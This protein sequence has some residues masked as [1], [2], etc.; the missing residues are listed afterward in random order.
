MVTDVELAV[1]AYR[2]YVLS[3]ANDVQLADRALGTR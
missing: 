3:F 1:L 2:S